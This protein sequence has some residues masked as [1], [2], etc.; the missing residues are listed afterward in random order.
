MFV[1]RYTHSMQPSR[2]FP[3]MIVLSVCQVYYVDHGFSVETSGTNLLD[4]HQDFL[5]LPFQAFNVRLAGLEAFGSHA[6]VVSSVEK[7]VVGK[8]LLME[9][10]EPC[11]ENETPVAVLYD[12]SQDDDININSA[13]R[14][15]LQDD[16]M[17]N[18]LTVKATY[19]DVCV[20]SVCADGI[21]YCQLP[22]RGTA[23]L[24]KLMEETETF[25]FSQFASSTSLRQ[26]DGKQT[27][28]QVAE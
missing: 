23:R 7:L 18:P 26:P 9:T 11:Q 17:K 14:K 12:T 16:T 8:I 10:L 15:A 25:F 28:Y 21:I 2:I 5:S 22:S 1:N 4:L 24:N 13:C 6:L 27:D 3:L 20:T 19:Q